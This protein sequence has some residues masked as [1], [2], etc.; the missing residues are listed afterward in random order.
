MP[1]ASVVFCFF[2]RDQSKYHL[3]NDAKRIVVRLLGDPVPLGSS[4]TGFISGGV[5]LG[6]G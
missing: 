1:N 2:G 5:A 4:S 3:S 6:G